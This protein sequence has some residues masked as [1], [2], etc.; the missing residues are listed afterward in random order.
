MPLKRTR[1]LWLRKAQDLGDEQRLRLD[2][3]RRQFGDLGRAWGIK[4][5]VM[6]LWTGNDRSILNA[7]ALPCLV[8]RD[9][10][11]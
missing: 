1:Y 6:S 2:G 3:L 5:W 9:P 10:H 8:D 11:S 4:E 7:T